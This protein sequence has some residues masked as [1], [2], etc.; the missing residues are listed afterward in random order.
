MSYI[1]PPH[2]AVTAPTADD[3]ISD[4]FVV[5]SR[6]VDTDAGNLYVCIDNSSGAAVWRIITR[7]KAAMLEYHTAYGVGGGNATSGAWRDLPGWSDN[8]VSLTCGLVS[9]EDDSKDV[10]L[11]KGHMYLVLASVP[12]YT[13][14]SAKIRL[15][16]ETADEAYIGGTVYTNSSAEIQEHVH[17]M[18]VVD[19]RE[20]TTDHVFQFQYR[21][22]TSC[23]FSYVGLGQ[24]KTFN[25][26][27][28]IQ[29]KV[30][31]KVLRSST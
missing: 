20:A 7:R 25:E 21:C 30:I 2:L 28:N 1:Q 19:L 14:D 12:V 24:R 18:Q 17:L 15:Y 23:L 27:F 6:W 11:A 26:E 29:G 3:D 5:G 22:E 10:T 4:G 9:V 16:D 13:V 31:I 8:I